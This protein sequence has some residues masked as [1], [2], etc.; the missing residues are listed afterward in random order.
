MIGKACAEL[1]ENSGSLLHFPQH[2]ATGIRRDIASVKMP[3]DFSTSHRMKFDWFRFTLCHQ[4]GRLRFGC[5]SLSQ[6]LNTIRGGLF[7]SRQQPNRSDY[8]KIGEKCGLMAST[9]KSPI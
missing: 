1:L 4:K 8:F 2:Q 7:W 6:S 3:N 5:F 9:S